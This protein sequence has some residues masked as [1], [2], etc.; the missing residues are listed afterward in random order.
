MGISQL[1]KVTIVVAKSELEEV[2]AKLFM[3]E[4]FHPSEEAPFYEDLRLVELKSRALELHS[5]LNY[6]I[7]KLGKKHDQQLAET[8][9]KVE[10]QSYSWADLL[11]HI[12]HQR[13]ELNAKLLCKIKLTEGDIANLFALR[14]AALTIFNS[15]RRIKTRHELKYA[16]TIEGYIPTKSE[17]RFREEFSRW[18]HHIEPVRKDEKAPYAPTLLS[19]PKFI[20]LFED[21]TIA[22][23]IPKYREIDPTP[24]IAF[25]FPFFY[26]IMFPDLGQGMLLILFGKLVSMQK[27]KAV[28]ILGKDDYDIRYICIDRRYDNRQPIW[29]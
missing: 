15:L 10:L 27:E 5:G 22:Q 26:G 21:L 4:E 13:D 7:D 17:Q 16:V 18:W 2:I 12:S 1:S 9:K 28:Q 14:E 25:V 23:G 19:N 29:P 3:F 11:R 24:F 6:M 20:K 8:T